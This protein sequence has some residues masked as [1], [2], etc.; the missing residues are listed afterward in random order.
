MKDLE[1]AIEEGDR[2]KALGIVEREL[3]EIREL[4]TN[5]FHI[6][7]NESAFFDN[8]NNIKAMLSAKP[9][10]EHDVLA[11]EQ[12]PEGRPKKDFIVT[13]EMARRALNNLRKHTE[14]ALTEELRLEE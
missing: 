7:E 3:K 13:I 8:I 1:D 6:Q 14:L 10:D 5:F 4:G 12:T 9:I 11:R 2:K